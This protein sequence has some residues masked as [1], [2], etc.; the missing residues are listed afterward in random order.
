MRVVLVYGYVRV[1]EKVKGVLNLSDGFC[2]KLHV[3]VSATLWG[4]DDFV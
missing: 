4:I 2:D 3:F 1:W